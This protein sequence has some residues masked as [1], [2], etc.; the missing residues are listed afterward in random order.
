MIGLTC[1]LFLDVAGLATVEWW[2]VV[3]LVLALLAI[4]LVALAWLTP[5]PSRLPWLAALGF[6]LWLLIVVAGA[7]AFS[8]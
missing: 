5:H 8:G 1:V 7:I 6:V 4:F 3:L 2:V